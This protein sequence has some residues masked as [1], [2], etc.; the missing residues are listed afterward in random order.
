MCSPPGCWPSSG[1]ELLERLC[2]WRNRECRWLGHRITKTSELML[3]PIAMTT[4]AATRV[5]PPPRIW[6]LKHA[7][8]QDRVLEQTRRGRLR[9]TGIENG[10]KPSLSTACCARIVP[11]RWPQPM[12]D[13][14][15]PNGKRIERQ[16][17]M[18]SPLASSVK[19]REACRPVEVAPGAASSRQE[20]A[21]DT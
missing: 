19:M 21:E 2:P 11:N 14:F 20:S 12:Y 1:C 8:H 16:P 13:G 7:L 18:Q 9:R 4:W 6:A 10:S 15:L 17:G 5:R 3:A